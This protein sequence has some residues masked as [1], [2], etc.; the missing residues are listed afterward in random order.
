MAGI[1]LQTIRPAAGPAVQAHSPR[2][3]ISIADLV[4]GELL[5]DASDLAHQDA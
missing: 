5:L 3:G 2:S 1:G 4:G